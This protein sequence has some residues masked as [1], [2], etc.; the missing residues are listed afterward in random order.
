MSNSLT[1]RNERRK[2]A[3]LF[4][5]TGHRY[6]EIKITDESE[7]AAFGMLGGEEYRVWKHGPAWNG[8]KDVMFLAVDGSPVTAV[9]TEGEEE[10]WV[11][12]KRFLEDLWGEKIIAGMKAQAPEIFN[13]LEIKWGASMTVAPV[14]VDPEAKKALDALKANEL[15]YES[16]IAQAA[17]VGKATEEVS[18]T[19][20]LI[21]FAMHAIIGAGIMYF[22][23]KQGII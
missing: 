14:I 21:E 10:R 2:R 23:V 6:E 20:L 13:L 7:Y 19:R 17:V 15:L 3:I 1:T 12:I 11:T 16:N 18:K 9:M 4:R 5:P 8:D 22:V